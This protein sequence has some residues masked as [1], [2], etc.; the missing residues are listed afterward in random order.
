MSERVA[1]SAGGKTHQGYSDKFAEK[2]LVSLNQ[3]NAANY[4][5][6]YSPLLDKLMG[7]LNS[8]ELVDQA[9]EESETLLGRTQALQG[10]Q[11][12]MGLNALT[13]AQRMALERRTEIRAA[14]T[15][16]GNV[17]RS[18]LA[19]NDM[20]MQNSNSLMQFAVQN[21]QSATRGL[22]EAAGLASGREQAYRNGKAQAR[23]ANTSLAAG[24]ATA[25]I[26]A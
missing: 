24:L 14:S 11:Q 1:Q 15:G 8:T 3:K 25:L 19:Q 2:T 6:N 26:L 21:D 23:S 10:K 4:K 20:N 5:Q 12:S 16:A 13:P 17:N 9:Q 7:Q 22:G 18:R